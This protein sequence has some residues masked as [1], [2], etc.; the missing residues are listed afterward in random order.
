[1]NRKTF[2]R[3]TLALLA[4]LCLA[5]GSALAQTFPNKQVNLMV[6]Y[7]A[8]GLSDAIARVIERPLTKVLG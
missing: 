7:P 8:G 2:H 4:G 6:P 5:S 1:M 3:S